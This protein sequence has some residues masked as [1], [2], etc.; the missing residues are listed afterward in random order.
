MITE[1]GPESDKQ[2]SPTFSPGV[3]CDVNSA[4]EYIHPRFYATARH[5]SR[6]DEK[7]IPDHH[8]IPEPPDLQPYKSPLLWSQQ[9]K[10]VTTVIACGVTAMAAY[11]AGECAPAFDQLHQAWGAERVPYNLSTTLFTLGFAVTPMV[12][13]PFS[14]SWGRRPVFLTS[15]VL[16]TACLAG[17]GASNSLAGLLVGRFFLGVSGS[18][19]SSIVG[20]VISDIYADH[21]RNVP[22]ALFSGATLFGTGIGPLMSSVIAFRTTWRWICYSQAIASAGFV[23]LLYFFYSETRQAVLD[24]R[25]TIALNSYIEKLEGAG[26]YG[27]VM[28]REHPVF[29]G[30]VLRVRYSVD[31][32]NKSMSIADKL[33]LSC[34]RPFAFLFTEPVVFFFSLWVAFS[35]A[36]LYLNF[37]S[38]PLVFST[39]WGFNLEETGAVFTVI[40]VAAVLATLLSIYQEKLALKYNLLPTT[41]EARLYFACIESVFLPI[42]L[43]WFGWTAQ[44]HIHWI[45][46]TLGIGCAIVGIFS[47]YLATF[48]Y[49]ADAYQGYASSAIAAQSFCRNLLGGVFPLVTNAMFTNLRYG[50]AASLLGGIGLL[51]TLVP[52]VLVAFGP[53]IRKKSKFARGDGISA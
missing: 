53:A 29:G 41:A 2:E 36:V 19:F 46:P 50:P 9:R 34:S 18:S 31:T 10:S 13:A 32:D 15:G 16:F 27:T 26:Y 12:L 35:W 44:T 4:I 39:T 24:E 14:E 21:E 8:S 43:F 23:V 49:L 48:N 20:G 11:A 38:I 45:V 22:M 30:R 6:Y 7:S 28:G 1:L 17:C 33:V 5:P 42:G 52:W 25:M 40:A 3:S 47:I 37:G 51:L